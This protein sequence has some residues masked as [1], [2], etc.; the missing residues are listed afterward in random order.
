VPPVEDKLSLAALEKQDIA[1]L[2]ALW[3]AIHG[4]DPPP[5]EVKVDE[6]ALLI[7]AALDRHLANTVEGVGGERPTKARRH[8]RMKSLG[9]LPIG[10]GEYRDEWI[11][12][13]FSLIYFHVDGTS[14][15]PDGDTEALVI[16]VC[17]RT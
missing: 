2:I 11:C 5:K 6:T 3:I 15:N 16:C 12:F 17:F 8:E 10:N 14:R 7:A 13:C 1:A 4:G 9:I